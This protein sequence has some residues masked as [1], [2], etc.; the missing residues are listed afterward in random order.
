MIINLQ[1]EWAIVYPEKLWGENTICCADVLCEYNN[2]IECK[3]CILRL[4]VRTIPQ[5]VSEGAIKF[6]DKED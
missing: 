2:N 1:G 6:L 4:A 3:H 5:L